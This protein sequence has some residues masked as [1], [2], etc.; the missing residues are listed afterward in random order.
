MSYSKERILATVKGN[1]SLSSFEAL[2]GEPLGSATVGTVD[3]SKPHELTVN[4]DNTRAF[5]SLYGDKDYGPNTPDNRLA[6]V[7]LEKMKLLGHVDLGLYL[8]PHALM[9][10]TNGM[11]WVTVDASRGRNHRTDG[12]DFFC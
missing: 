7:D 6:V 10:D 2:S 1:V 3:I 11:I 9:T 4:K 5:V 8:G 12:C